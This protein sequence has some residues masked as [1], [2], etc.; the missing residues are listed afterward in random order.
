MK[1]LIGSVLLST[2]L[3]MVTFIGLLSAS[4]AAAA[5]GYCAF[6]GFAFPLLW[7]AL[8]RFFS[9]SVVLQWKRG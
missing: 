9:R 2:V 7:V 6:S 5:G 4:A 8:Y 3:V 1:L